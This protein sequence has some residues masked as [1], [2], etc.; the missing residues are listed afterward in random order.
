VGAD[1]ED[2]SPFVPVRERTNG[3]AWT[4]E[5]TRKS[6]ARGPAFA[7][8]DCHAAAAVRIRGDN[9]P[10]P[11]SRPPGHDAGTR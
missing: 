6:T 10:I 4:S 1:D 8:F 9:R 11:F 2:V 3:P 5:H 7:R